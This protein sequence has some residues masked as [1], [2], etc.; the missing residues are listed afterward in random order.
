MAKQKNHIGIIFKVALGKIMA[1]P[2]KSALLEGD[3]K[4]SE[5]PRS[6]TQDCIM[7]QSETTNVVT[8][9]SPRNEHDTSMTAVQETSAGSITAFPEQSDD[10]MEYVHREPTI[11][12]PFDQQPPEESY[13]LLA[14]CS[15]QPHA[16]FPEQSRSQECSETLPS[17]VNC[18]VMDEDTVTE[19]D[20]LDVCGGRPMNEYPREWFTPPAPRQTPEQ[21]LLAHGLPPASQGLFSPPTSSGGLFASAHL[22]VFTPDEPTEEGCDEIDSQPEPPL[23]IESCQNCKHVAVKSSNV[24]G[25]TGPCADAEPRADTD[26]RGRNGVIQVHTC[27]S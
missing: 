10:V 5:S 16:V 9:N 11:A 15:S 25:D 1:S 23:D 8:S 13:Q 20:D 6:L 19:A 21:H 26:I 22:P 4:R 12:Q 2:S 24:A 7:D 14:S 18:E 3:T 17:E 27:S